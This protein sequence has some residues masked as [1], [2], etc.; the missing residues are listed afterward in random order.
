M[1]YIKSQTRRMILLFNY[2]S[3]Y[4]C[5]KVYIIYNELFHI[6]MQKTN[7]QKKNLKRQKNLNLND[8]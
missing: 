6:N 1:Y 2:L 7:K 3:I 8:Q 5:N 4:L